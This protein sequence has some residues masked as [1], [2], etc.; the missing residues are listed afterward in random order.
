MVPILYLSL[1]FLLATSEFGV[2]CLELL[3]PL[4]QGLDLLVQF[5]P[6]VLY[7]LQ[8]QLVIVHLLL[9]LIQLSRGERRG[10]KEDGA[11]RN[12]ESGA[13][14]REKKIGKEPGLVL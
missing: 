10:V 11:E 9:G 2:L 4:L 3:E 7:L 1:D 13:Q 12:S 5:P 8:L 14:E 6:P